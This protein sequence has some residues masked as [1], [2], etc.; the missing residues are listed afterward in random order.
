M[1]IRHSIAH[2]FGRR[3][4]RWVIVREV[5]A[6]LGDR[7]GR[8]VDCRCDCGVVKRVSLQNIIK[9]ATRSCGCLRNE[10]TGARNRTHGL[11]RTPEHQIWCGMIKRCENPHTKGFEHYG[12][13]GI[14][15]WPA[16]RHDCLAWLSYV[17][18]R[19]SPQH[20]I[21]RLDNAKGYIPGNIVWA[22][23]T[24]QANNQTRNHRI[25]FNGETRNLAQWAQRIG[26]RPHDLLNRLQRGWPLE[27][28]LQTPR[29]TNGAR[30]TNVYLE[31][32][33]QRRHLA[34]WARITGLGART[35]QVRLKYGYT[36]ERALTQPVR[37][38]H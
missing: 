2:W 14:A 17:G 3:F 38:R 1:A 25:T 37:K 20:T 4:H 12:G 6:P 21:E 31:H 11:S 8:Y 18:K 13:K 19:P 16:W 10:K 7:Y 26:I 5:A 30:R 27:R 29:L 36:V 35:I 33:G 28:A 32:D 15:V 34:D 24:T 22:D 9:G 23:R